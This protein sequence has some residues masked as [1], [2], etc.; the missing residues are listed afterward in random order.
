MAMNHYKWIQS[1][2]TES[3]RKSKPRA[4]TQRLQ[5]LGLNDTNDDCISEIKFKC[6]QPFTECKIQLVQRET[7]FP[8]AYKYEPMPY[9]FRISFTENKAGFYTRLRFLKTLEYNS[10]TGELTF[11]GYNEDFLEIDLSEVPEQEKVH[12]YL[13]KEEISKLHTWLCSFAELRDTVVPSQ[14]GAQVW[15]ARKPIEL[16][17]PQVFHFLEQEWKSMHSKMK[18]LESKVQ[19]LELNSGHNSVLRTENSQARNLYDVM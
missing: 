6:V 12:I 13:S 14:R 17:V 15:R 19:K 10:T 4:D 16:N 9:L 18:I 7:Q 2:E 8:T 3:G 5:E 1:Q 11:G